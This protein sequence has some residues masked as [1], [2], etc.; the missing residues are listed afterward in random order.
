MVVLPG[1]LEVKQTIHLTNM[2]SKQSNPGVIVWRGLQRAEGW[3]VGI[4]LLNPQMD[5][6]GL[7]L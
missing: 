4:E 5:F 2:I 3:E 1:S 7:D 6:W